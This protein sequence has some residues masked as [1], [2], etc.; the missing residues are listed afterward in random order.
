MKKNSAIFVMS[1]ILLN[2]SIR[3]KRSNEDLYIK[4]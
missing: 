4:G 1:S 2:N 3:N